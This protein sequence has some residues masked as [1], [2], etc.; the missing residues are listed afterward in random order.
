MVPRFALV[1][2]VFGLAACAGRRSGDDGMDGLG[3]A[4]GVRE[5]ITQRDR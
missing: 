3:V 2:I 4:R 1:L 5:V